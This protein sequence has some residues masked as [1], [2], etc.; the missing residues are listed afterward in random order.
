MG[1]SGTLYTIIEDAKKELREWCEENPNNDPTNEAIQEICDGAV[2]TYYV[3]IMEIGMQNLDLACSEPINGTGDE[4]TAISILSAV[5]YETISDELNEE[6]R[7]IEQE[8]EDEEMDALDEEVV[9]EDESEEET[10]EK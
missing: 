2:P 8:R 4:N 6:W 10:E 9:E 3:G 7:V 5:I 1:Y